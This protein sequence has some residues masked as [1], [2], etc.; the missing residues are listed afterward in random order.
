MPFLLQ[1]EPDSHT[2]AV[3]DILP[4]YRRKETWWGEKQNL[5]TLLPKFGTSEASDHRDSIYALLGIASDARVSNTLCPNYHVSLGHAICHTISFLLFDET[6]QPSA[7]PFPENMDF[8]TFLRILPKLPDYILGWALQTHV[9]ATAAA[10]LPKAGDIKTIYDLKDITLVPARSPVS[11][12]ISS[13][14]DFNRTFGAILEW[15]DAN[16]LIGND[17]IMQAVQSRRLHLLKHIIRHPSAKPNNLTVDKSGRLLSYAAM[18]GD[19]DL[20]WRVARI[21]TSGNHADL[22]ESIRQIIARSKIIDRLTN[23]RVSEDQASTK[24]AP[25]G[26]RLVRFIKYSSIEKLNPNASAGAARTTRAF[27]YDYA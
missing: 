16:V 4:G 1:L 11:W 25:S 7:R 2:Q 5:E 9:D 21:V 24:Y 27:D 26:Q 10:L 20:F 12:I 13:K 8:P 15:E 19:R 18:S 6:Y 14:V 23:K 17:E 22:E 3:L